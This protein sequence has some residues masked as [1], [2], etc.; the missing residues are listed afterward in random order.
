M[1]KVTVK[2]QSRHEVDGVRDNEPVERVFL[3]KGNHLDALG[4]VVMA[5]NNTDTN[6]NYGT[7]TL[8]IKIEKV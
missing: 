2:F 6:V 4:N 3:Q 5:M 8:A 7:E 1:W